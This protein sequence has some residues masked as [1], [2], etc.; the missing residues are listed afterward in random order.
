[1]EKYYYTKGMCELQSYLGLYPVLYRKV[2]ETTYEKVEMQCSDVEKGDC[3]KKTACPLF[4]NAPE[5][6]V[7]NGINL[8]DEK[9]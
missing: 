2:E 5:E 8:R 7:D 3:D 1:M 9:Y 6:I 4:L